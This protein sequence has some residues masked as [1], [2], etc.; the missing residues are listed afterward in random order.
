MSVI[1]LTASSV[2]E[3]MPSTRW[4][5]VGELALVMGLNNIMQVR[6]TSIDC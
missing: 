1:G 2:S 3:R 6:Q 4:T 5:D